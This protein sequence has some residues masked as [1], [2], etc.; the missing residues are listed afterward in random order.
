MKR[1]IDEELDKLK[2]KILQMGSVA[3]E[4]VRLSAKMIVDRQDDVSDHIFA[5]EEVVNRLQMEIDEMGVRI[6]ALYQPEAMDLR[7]IMAALKIN[8][9]L[10]RIADQA[11]NITQTAHFHFLKEAPVQT[12]EIPQMAVIAQ[13]MIKDC[14]DAYSQKDVNLAQSVLGSDA[15]E[16]NLKQKAMNEIIHLIQASPEKSK[17]FIDLLLVAKNFEK[18]GDHATNIAEDVIFM[19]L[20]KD[21]RHHARDSVNIS[22]PNE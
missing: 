19:V 18:I 12:M 14:L 9:D 22:K 4:M 15:E 5:N 6:L 1:H 13:K 11:I 17:Q 7:N 20:G 8:S 2:E 10:E 3:E 21:I 16:D